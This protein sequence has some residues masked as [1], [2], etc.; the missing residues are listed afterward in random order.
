[1]HFCLICVDNHLKLTRIVVVPGNQEEMRGFIRN[2]AVRIRFHG[3]ES[4]CSPSNRK[5]RGDVER[6][7]LLE[8]PLKVNEK[9]SPPP[10]PPPPPESPQCS[11][12]GSSSPFTGGGHHH[13][14][15]GRRRSWLFDAS[16]GCDNIELT[17]NKHVP[18]SA[19]GGGISDLCG[20]FFCFL[21]FFLF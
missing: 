16:S 2:L 13:H 4:N 15:R 17:G 19:S 12:A 11:A 10:P 14:H 20:G 8:L 3:N 7:T 21:Y 6:S 9:S 18:D 5:H 1:M